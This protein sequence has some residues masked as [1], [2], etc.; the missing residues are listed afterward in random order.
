MATS[1]LHI[2]FDRMGMSKYATCEAGLPI[3]TDP[4]IGVNR[5]AQVAPPVS[6]GHAL[7]VME[8]TTAPPTEEE[9]L[10]GDWY[11][12]GETSSDEMI[13]VEP[14]KYDIEEGLTAVDLAVRQLENIGATEFGGY[15]TFTTPDASLNY[16][17]GESTTTT[18]ALIGFT[19]EEIAAVAA[20]MSGRRA[21]VVGRFTRLAF[22]PIQPFF[23]FGP[24]GDPL[25][26]PTRAK[27]GLVG[28]KGNK[29]TPAVPGNPAAIEPV[30][31]YTTNDKGDRVP[32]AVP[33]PT[34]G[35]QPGAGGPEGAITLP[36]DRGWISQIGQPKNEAGQYEYGRGGMED[37]PI[38]RVTP[39][40]EVGEGPLTPD[41]LDLIAE[42]MAGRKDVFEGKLKTASEKAAGILEP[43]MRPG[44]DNLA[45]MLAQNFWTTFDKIVYGGDK[46]I[47]PIPGPKARNL[48]ALIEQRQAQI[49]NNNAGIGTQEQM[50]MSDD[51]VE[52]SVFAM[53]CQALGDLTPELWESN[54]R[55]YLNL[56]SLLYSGDM[57]LMRINPL[58]VG[59]ES[60]Q[61]EGMPERD[62]RTGAP[63]LTGPP[64]EREEGSEAWNR[65]KTEKTQRWD[66]MTAD[67]GMSLYPPMVQ[68]HIQL[69][70]DTANKGANIPKTLGEWVAK[71][72]HPRTG[73]VQG[74]DPLRIIMQAWPMVRVGEDAMKDAAARRKMIRN[75][76]HFRGFTSGK[77]QFEVPM[78][79]AQ[80][81]E[82]MNTTS[83]EE[84]LDTLKR[85]ADRL[86]AVKLDDRLKGSSFDDVVA[87]GPAY[88]DQMDEALMEMA[89][90][91]GRL[92]SGDKLVTK[93]ERLN[94]SYD[95]GQAT[96][97]SIF[98]IIMLLTKN[99]K[100]FLIERLPELA[101]RQGLDD[102]AVEQ[103][104]Q[105]LSGSV[106]DVDQQIPGQDQTDVQAALSLAT[107]F[108]RAAIMAD[109]LGCYDIA[110]F[111][112]SA[113][114][115]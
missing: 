22:R 78:P 14:D 29:E 86:I 85:G 18:V 80:A 68:Q 67:E 3:S 100:N 106:L 64:P 53:Q 109:E 25:W 83:E 98:Y 2:L 88:I 113:F 65:W 59:I 57:E 110:D 5:F 54:P 114:I 74:V 36:G 12:E 111:M 46:G 20:A 73:D 69:W 17:T 19:P 34:L 10:E 101:K 93:D 89:S 77:T 44:E 33:A 16:R 75:V 72:T 51:Q 107:G 26:T 21:S 94:L 15:D 52:N 27:K 37:W 41:E 39:E 38:Q 91:A 30:L 6:R 105:Q 70:V 112:E 87:A 71:N 90:A 47:A 35:L 13:P 95:Y 96:K 84:L 24:A 58:K 49:A 1:K 76:S 115:V 60:A 56:L 4:T 55:E 48:V 50:M 103:L 32:E 99:W 8:T 97:M 42:T 43:F 45:R 9:E 28:T 108:I 23:N 66:A 104:R 81:K 61:D 7:R 79:M 62:S 102:A 92:T 31:T 40:G 63:I 11:D 82:K